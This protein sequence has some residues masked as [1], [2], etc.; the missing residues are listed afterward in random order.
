MPPDVDTEP[1]DTEP[2]T[3]PE[4]MTPR[5]QLVRD[6]AGVIA[7]LSELHSKIDESVSVAHATRDAVESVA[8]QV[9]ALT[10][11]LHVLTEEADNREDRVTAIEHRL[12]PHDTMPPTRSNGHG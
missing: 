8:S 7:S 10:Q 3:S 2:D 5:E 6:V 1:P 11:A 4:N 12:R 9:L